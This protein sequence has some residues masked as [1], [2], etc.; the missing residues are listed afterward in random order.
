MNWLI[1]VMLATFHG[2]VYI[3]TEPTFETREECIQSLKDPEQIKLYTRKLIL[4][5][6]KQMPIQLINCLEEKT[7]KELLA[8]EKGD[9]A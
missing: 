4:E 1:I 2:D 8:K 9:S 6:G 3:F 5:Y 7:I